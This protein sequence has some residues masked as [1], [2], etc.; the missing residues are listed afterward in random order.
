MKNYELLLILNARLEEE[1]TNALLEKV[2]GFL[3]GAKAEVEKVDKWGI[4]KLAYPINYQHEGFYVIYDLKAP[5]DLV[6]SVE[7][8]LRIEEDIVRVLFTVK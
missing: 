5:A 2:N 6:A 7:P 4:K 1:K 8:K 3:T